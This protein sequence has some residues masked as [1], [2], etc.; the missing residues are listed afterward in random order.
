MI[1]VLA[2]FIGGFAAGVVLSISAMVATCVKYA[3]RRDNDA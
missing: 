3:R 1:Q 2:G